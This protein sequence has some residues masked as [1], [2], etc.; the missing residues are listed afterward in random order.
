M[1]GKSRYVIM[2]T[3]C[4]Q[5]IE[6]FGVV[7][8][9]LAARQFQLEGKKGKIKTKVWARFDIRPRGLG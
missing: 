2:L 3:C 6:M 7:L 4:L 5:D 8:V 1:R 9:M